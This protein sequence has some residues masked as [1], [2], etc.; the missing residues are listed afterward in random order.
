MKRGAASKDDELTIDLRLSR[1]GLAASLAGLALAGLAG[2]LA[3]RTV[4]GSFEL[5]EPTAVY[6]GLVTTGRTLLARRSGGVGVHMRA[7]DAG[8]IVSSDVYVAGGAF[9]SGIVML[10]QPAPA[11]PEPGRFYFPPRFPAGAFKCVEF[12]RPSVGSPLEPPC[13]AGLGGV[14]AASYCRQKGRALDPSRAFAHGFEVEYATAP[15]RGA[16]QDF[17]AGRGWT[18][19]PASAGRQRVTLIECCE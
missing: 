12:A 16:C 17:V 13:G 14:A 1:G 9:V 8:L 4:A 15:A 2:A 19:V 6:Q 11:S 7:P 5:A 18:P 10:N 3:A